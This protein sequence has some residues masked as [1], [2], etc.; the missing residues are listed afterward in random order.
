MELLGPKP[1]GRPWASDAGGQHLPS[2]R[3]TC[4]Q[5][6]G[7]VT[8]GDRQ[9]LPVAGRQAAEGL[10]LQV[11]PLADGGRRGTS[12]LLVLALCSK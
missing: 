4:Y 8:E 3:S 10:V 7:Q 9:H 2:M 1:C 12:C 11:D 6:R 5:E